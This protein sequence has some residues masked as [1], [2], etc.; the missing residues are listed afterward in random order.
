M[1]T[2]KE[3]K[4]MV[5]A[6]FDEYS[7][8]NQL[9]GESEVGD[10][11][12]RIPMLVNML[13]MEWCRLIKISTSYTITH[14]KIEALYTMPSD[15]MEIDKIVKKDRYGYKEYYWED[16]KT[17]KL[18]DTDEGEYKV[19]YF[20]YPVKLTK[21]S[22][23]TVELDICDEAANIIPLKIASIIIQPEKADISSR[24]LQLYENEKQMVIVRQTQTIKNVQT[25]FSI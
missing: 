11:T 5:L 15:F 17:L 18:L 6:L 12:I 10:Y 9:I 13:Q 3:V 21:V 14:P 23:D 25:V 22:L 8:D 4:E 7:V 19:Y 16:R 1:Y 24:L 20:K 2:L